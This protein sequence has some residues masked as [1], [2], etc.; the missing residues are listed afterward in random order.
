M[1][2]YIAIALALGAV[3]TLTWYVTKKVSDK[4]VLDET[5]QKASSSAKSNRTVT[6]K[7]A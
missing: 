5:S 6:I 4:S 7:R 2:K 1:I 3:I